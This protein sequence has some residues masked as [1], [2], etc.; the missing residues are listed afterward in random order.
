VITETVR[1]MRIKHNHFL[2]HF[3][4]LKEGLDIDPL[5][6]ALEKNQF[7]WDE[8]KL[9]QDTQGSPHKYTETIFVR[10]CEELTVHSAFNDL[11]AINYP[12]IDVIP[13]VIP[14][15]EEVIKTSKSQKLGRVLI[16]KLKA[17]SKIAPH[18][19]EGIVCASYERFHIPLFSEEGNHFYAGDPNG[20]FED[21]HMLPGQLWVFNNKET[22]WLENKSSKPRIHLIVD[23]VAPQFR[24]DLH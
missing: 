21:I 11:D 1:D 22:H 3:E 8:I 5:L 14:L 7:L 19:D 4:L 2:K 23:A 15:I 20:S 24:R 10:W 13:E 9:R 18:S 6:S 17:G 16:T 12:A